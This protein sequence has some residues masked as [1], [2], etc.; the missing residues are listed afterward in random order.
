MIQQKRIVIAGLAA[1]LACACDKAAPARQMSPAAPSAAA[2][3]AAVVVG[4]TA[5]PACT[6]DV[7]TTVNPLPALHI[8]EAWLNV[9]IQNAGSS[10]NCGQIRSLD[11]KIDVVTKMLD[12]T[13]PNFSAAC[14]AST[15]LVNELQ[16]LVSRGQLASPTF[17]PPVPNG[18]TT[19]L[20][21]AEDLSEHWC[22][23][24]RGQLTGPRS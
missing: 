4:P 6:V 14:G 2:E 11:A 24:A 17:P 7:G 22:E 20:G 12:Q 9:S 18:P 5:A 1:L 16:S 3:T 23:A 13:P 15:A 19:A 8:L 21:A 10:L